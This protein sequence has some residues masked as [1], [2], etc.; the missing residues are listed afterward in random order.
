M[1]RMQK[2]TEAQ[3]V[4]RTLLENEA[5]TASPRGRLV[6]LKTPQGEIVADW[7]GYYDLREVGGGVHHSVGYRDPQGGWSHGFLHP[8]HEILDPVPSHEEWAVQQAKDEA[9]R[10]ARIAAMK[11][12][13]SA[14]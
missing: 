9:E 13:I 14:G 1:L 2:Y 4:V 5:I 11:K 3:K 8:E 12:E 6:R 10:Q 7:N